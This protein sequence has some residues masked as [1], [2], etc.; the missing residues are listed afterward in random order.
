LEKLFVKP[1]LQADKAYNNNVSREVFEDVEELY[2]VSVTMDS[3]N[4]VPE[5]YEKCKS[6]IEEK[7]KSSEMKAYY[8]LNIEELEMLLFMIEKEYDIFEML[9]SYFG[10]KYLMPFSNYIN[11]F[12]PQKVEMTSY[13]KEI[14]EEAAA[15][16]KKAYGIE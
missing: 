13:M 11:K 1:I 5:Y 7:R 9:D 14:Y 8:N 2:V 15:E 6:I 12:C 3:I 10:E 16:M 4:A